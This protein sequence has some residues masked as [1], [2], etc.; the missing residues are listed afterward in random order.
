MCCRN[1]FLYV[2]IWLKKRSISLPYTFPKI[3]YSKK[4][5]CLKPIKAGGLHIVL[6]HFHIQAK[7]PNLKSHLRSNI[8]DLLEKKY[9][10][11]FNYETPIEF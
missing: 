7:Y 9:F 3:D 6:L 2:Y 1:A 8:V 11:L 5:I 10:L 4:N